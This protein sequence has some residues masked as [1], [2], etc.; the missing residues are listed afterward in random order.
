[1]PHVALSSSHIGPLSQLY[2]HRFQPNASKPAL[3][4]LLRDLASGSD[5]CHPALASVQLFLLV[6][7]S[8][9]PRTMPSARLACSTESAS[10]HDRSSSKL[11]SEG[12]SCDAAPQRELPVSPRAPCATTDLRDGIE[13]RNDEPPFVQIVR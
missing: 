4:G 8:S 10:L 3:R 12:A 5:A 6:P 13:L 2:N 11:V 1:M 7:L 9:L